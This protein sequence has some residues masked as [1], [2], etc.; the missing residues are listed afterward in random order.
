M[1]SDVTDAAIDKTLEILRKQRRSF[2][3]RANDAGGPGGRPRDGG[4]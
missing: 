1:N 3:L 2:A 4:L